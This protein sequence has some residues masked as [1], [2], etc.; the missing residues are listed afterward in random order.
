MDTENTTE[1]VE[2]CPICLCEINDEPVCGQAWCDECGAFVRPY[3][4]EKEVGNE[5]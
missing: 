5:V 3:V 2:L 4:V 1:F